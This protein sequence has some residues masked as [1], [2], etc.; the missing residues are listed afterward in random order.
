MIA[1]HS[2]LWYYT[3]RP[4]G[5]S[6]TIM[7]K[8]V[9]TPQT[10]WSINNEAAGSTKEMNDGHQHCKGNPHFRTRSQPTP[11]NSDPPAHGR[12]GPAGRSVSLPRTSPP[13][14]PRPDLR[15]LVN[16]QSLSGLMYTYGLSRTLFLVRFLFALRCSLALASH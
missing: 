16:A 2:N 12:P 4:T 3:Q 5:Y 15:P 8:V 9:A 11:A 1:Y 6:P 14:D 7:I 13:A 10:G